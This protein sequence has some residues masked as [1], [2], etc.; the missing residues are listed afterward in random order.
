[1][2]LPVE[3]KVELKDGVPMVSSQQV[4]EK[5]SK[6]H[7][8]VLKAIQEIEMSD[9]FRG[10]NFEPA[11]YLDAQGKPRPMFWMTRNGFWNVAMTFSGKEAAKLREGIISALDKAE[12]M[13]RRGIEALDVPLL[14]E[15][16]AKE[17]RQVIHER[18]RMADEAITAREQS[19]LLITER[20]KDIDKQREWERKFSEAQRRLTSV[21]KHA[22]QAKS[23]VEELM[24]GVGDM[25]SPIDAGNVTNLPVRDKTDKSA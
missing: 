5:F 8:N 13:M 12:E 22:W 24:Q 2:N 19:K 4:A 18:D 21:A 23:E 10:L 11:N 6:L 16:A 14:L 15:M 3:I 25:F 20:T 9:E 7:K 17:Y 1:M